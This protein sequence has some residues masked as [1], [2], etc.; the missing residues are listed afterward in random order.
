MRQAHHRSQPAIQGI[1]HARREVGVGEGL[2]DHARLMIQPPL[3][4]DC[5]TGIA[6][7]EKDLEARTTTAGL[8]GELVA[9]ASAGKEEVGEE[10]VDIVRL[11]VEEAE[12]AGRIRRPEDAVAELSQRFRRVGPNTRVV[13][14]L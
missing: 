10:Q 4:E 14:S 8:G 3:I 1:T 5:V 12:A 7:R 13:R 9:V 6:G 11:F 2:G